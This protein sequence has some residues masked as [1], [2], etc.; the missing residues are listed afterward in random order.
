LL[1][2]TEAN[3]EW[4]VRLLVARMLAYD[5]LKKEGSLVF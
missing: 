3:K 1:H 5:S 4:S 2:F